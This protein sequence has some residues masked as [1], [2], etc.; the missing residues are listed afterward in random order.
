[1]ENFNKRWKVIPCHTGEVCWCR[2]I[3]TEDYQDG[4]SDDKYIVGD[5]AMDKETAEYFVKLHNE[6]LD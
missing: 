4:D 6:K 3:V 5:A 1:M 2:C